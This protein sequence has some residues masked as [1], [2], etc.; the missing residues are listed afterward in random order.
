MTIRR[1]THMLATLTTALLL[2]SCSGCDQNDRPV[3]EGRD[4]QWDKEAGASDASAFMNVAIPE[5]ATQTK[6]AVQINPQEDIYLLTFVTS[7]KTAEEIAEDLHLQEPLKAQKTDFAPEGERFAHLGLPE[8]QTLKGVRWAG[9]CPPC[10]SDHRRKKA[11]WID[12][13]VEAL[14]AD[15]ARV[16]LQAF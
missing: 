11:Q 9:V 3:T 1:G 14:E 2:V 7:E 13:Y 12:V 4:Y 5:G 15:R 10:V 16:Y 6:G 8:P